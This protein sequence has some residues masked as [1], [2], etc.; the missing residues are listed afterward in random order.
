[1]TFYPHVDPDTGELYWT[2]DGGLE[3][4]DDFDGLAT[5]L[6]VSDKLGTI[7]LSVSQAVDGEGDVY[8]SIALHVGEDVYTGQILIEGNLNVSGQLSAEALYAAEGDIADLQVDK[9]ST[10]RRIPKYLASDT[11]DDNYVKIFDEK[12]C[13]MSGVYSNGTEQARDPYGVP[14][15]WESDPSASGVVIGA[16]GYPYLNGVRIFT[17]TTVTSYPVMVYTYN[18]LT[19]AKIEFTRNNGTYI[20]VLTLGAGDGNGND[21]ATIA[22]K[23]G[24]LEIHYKDGNGN[25]IGMDARSSGYVDIT[26]LRKVTAIN[27]HGWN[28]GSFTVTRQGLAAV[29]YAVTFDGSGQPTRITGNGVD[30]SITW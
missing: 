29:E 7:R 13:F 12:M 28:S 23:A 8:A 21:M 17:T 25:T 1:V 4:P 10:S 6:Y 2:N 20:P 16:N 9:L 3:N 5:K 18:E 14:L 30:C 15:Y 26:G 27:L 19:K 11:S 22:K 24:G